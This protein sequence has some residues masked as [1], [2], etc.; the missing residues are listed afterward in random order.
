MKDPLVKRR[1]VALDFP[2][3]RCSER[4]SDNKDATLLESMSVWQ[5]ITES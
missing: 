5:L 4:L 3:A 2:T 1:A